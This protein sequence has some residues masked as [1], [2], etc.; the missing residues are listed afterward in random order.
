ME[1]GRDKLG[2]LNPFVEALVARQYYEYLR[3]YVVVPELERSW[4]EWRDGDDYRQG[5][6]AAKLARA[7]I[8]QD[9]LGF[10]RRTAIDLA[11]L[12]AMPRWLTVGERD[13]ALVGIEAA[14]ELPGLT[15]FLRTPEAQLEY[16]QIVP[17]PNDPA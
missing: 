16:Y 2:H 9:P 14:G 12:W 11:G 1:S 5:Q 6:L 13:A 7:Y 4:P 3:W 8:A 15:S 17:D 10:A